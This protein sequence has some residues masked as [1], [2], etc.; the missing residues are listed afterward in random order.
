MTD[1]AV[2]AGTFADLKTVKTRSV[3]QMIVEVPIESAGQVVEAFGFPQPGNEVPVAVARLTGTK[4][5][6]DKGRSWDNMPRAQQAGILCADR[7]FQR[8][9]GVDNEN[10]AALRVRT[11]LEVPSRSDIDA[12]A[13]VEWD[14]MVSD[15]RIHQ[16]Y[17]DIR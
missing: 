4:A 2:I 3:V 9:L 12:L 15:F 7:K 6:E 5:P 8:W 10:T 17:G 11:K 1:A 13:P 16:R 14:A